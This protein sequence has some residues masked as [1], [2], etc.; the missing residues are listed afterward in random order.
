MTTS[1]KIDVTSV[2]ENK[3]IEIVRVS[4]DDPEFVQVQTNRAGFSFETH[5]WDGSSVY[6]RE[7]DDV[8]VEEVTV[9][10]IKTVKTL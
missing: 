8:D 9:E 3:R 5:V 7:V 2:G 6:I 4:K 1:I 10:E